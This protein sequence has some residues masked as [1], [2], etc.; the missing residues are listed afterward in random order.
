MNKINQA[1]FSTAVGQL[2]NSID[3]EQNENIEKACRV[4]YESISSGGL[5]H[6]FSTGH[7]HMVA[8]EFFYRAGGLIPVNPILVPFLMQHEGAVSSTKYERLTGIAEIIFDGADIKK[9][10]PMLIVSNS[11]INAVPIEMAMRARE[12]GNPVIALTSASV[13]AETPSRHIS[14]KHLYECADIVIDSGVPVGDCVMS[15][16]EGMKTGAVST[17]IS[18]YTV[19]KIVI[20]VVNKYIEKGETP[21]IYKSANRAGGDEYNKLF[22][23]KYKGRIRSL[24]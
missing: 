11:G 16:G 1:E 5:L 12:N 10:E 23:D 9:G 2:L 14:G 15:C 18:A 13:S 21:P 19:Q 7:S 22:T 6:V 24:F 17:I 20:G 4:I 8:E 3:V